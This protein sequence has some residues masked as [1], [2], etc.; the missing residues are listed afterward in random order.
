MDLLATTVPQPPSVA[1]EAVEVSKTPCR[2]PQ[3]ESTVA[4]GTLD[5]KD[6]FLLPEEPKT[7][8]GREH[9][10]HLSLAISRVIHMKNFGEEKKKK[11][12]EKPKFE[13]SN[14]QP[15]QRSAV[16]PTRFLFFL[17]TQRDY[18]PWPLTFH[19]Y[20]PLPGPVLGVPPTWDSHVPASSTSLLHMTNAALE[21]GCG[22]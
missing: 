6:G 8:E 16:Y 11:R 21:A 20:A 17:S 5:S 1:R 4:V 19:R 13:K 9:T 7:V 14:N 3:W 2:S 22:G 18:T 12:T 10:V 15:G